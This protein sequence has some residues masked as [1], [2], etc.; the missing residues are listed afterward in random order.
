MARS[1]RLD[2]LESGAYTAGAT[3]LGI[4]PEMLREEPLKP[5]PESKEAERARVIR[6]NQRRL[7][8]YDTL[9]SLDGGALP[10]D[11]GTYRLQR[12]EWVPADQPWTDPRGLHWHGKYQL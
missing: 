2:D 7:Q 1:Q 4:V 3:T 12:P 9:R 6:A 10:P 8:D 11:A 5:P